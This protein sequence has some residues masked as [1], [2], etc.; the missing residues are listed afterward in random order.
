VQDNQVRGN[1]QNG[2]VILRSA[3]E[4]RIINNVATDN[5]RLG[6]TGIFRYFDLY[7]E[8]AGCDDNVWNGNVWGSGLYA[9][10]CVTNGGSGPPA[11]TGPE[12]FG[13]P[14]CRDGFD[15]DEDG[16]TDEFQD[17]GC[18]PPPP[19]PEGPEGDRTCSDGVDNDQDNFTDGE[20]PD[21]NPAA[22]EGTDF[23]DTCFD[24]NDNDKDGLVDG[25][26]PDCEFSGPP[27]DE[28]PVF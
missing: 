9:P 25:F 21:C 14:A 16:L 2:I 5:N 15:N 8:N 1:G 18:Q 12:L 28:G 4:N 10:V 11:P 24:A 26:D 23:G 19:E 7:D 22:P 3:R 13:D 6:A 20:D 27:V 17:P